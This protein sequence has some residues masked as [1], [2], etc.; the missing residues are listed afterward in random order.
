MQIAILVLI[1]THIVNFKKKKKTFAD[2]LLTPCHSCHSF[3]SWKEIKVFDENIT[4]FFFFLHKMQF[5]GH[6]TVQGP[7]D[8]FSANCKLFTIYQ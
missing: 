5:T 4:G 8:I 7:K 6:Q 2:N 1:L 3:F